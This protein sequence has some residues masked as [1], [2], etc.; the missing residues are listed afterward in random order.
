LRPI[1]ALLLLLVSAPLYGQ[2]YTLH[3]GDLTMTIE[4]A[5]ARYGFKQNGH[6][7]VE[8]S[9]S[10]GM[11]IGGEPVMHASKI[12]CSTDKCS[13]HLATASGDRGT[14]T[15]ELTAHTAQLR[16]VPLSPEMEVGFVTAGAQPAYGLAD[17]AVLNKN[18]STDVTGFSNDHFLSGEGLVRLVS[19]F[20]IYPAQRFAVLLIDPNAKIVHTS[21]AEI[22][23]GVH[24]A[25]AEGTT[26]QYF[27]G[28]MH[29]IYAGY[30]LARIH[31]G[32]KVMPPKYEMFGVGWEA[33]GAL[34]WQ[35][36]QKTI[37][38]S[39]DRYLSLGYPLKWIVI[40]SGFW[41]SPREFNATTSFGLFD[42]IKYP[43]PHG[44]TA[45]FHDEHLK[46]LLGLRIS[47][48][49]DGPFS[50]EGVAHHYFLSENGQAIVFH[51]SWPKSPYYLLDA[52]NPA[53]LDWYMGLT[54]R[55]KDFGVDGYK[56]DFYGYHNL[57]DDKI[58]PVNDRLMAEGADI[59]ERNGYLSV[60]GD[61]QRVNDF[62]YD[63]GQDRG[64]V[65]ALA[66]AYSGFPFVYPDI[67]GGTFGEQHF[68]TQRTPAM[69]TY[70]ERNAQW[71][72]LHSSMSMGEPPWSFQNA[73]VG[74]IML[75]AAQLHDR[76]QPYL[77]SFA[78]RATEDGF[79]WTMSPL[80]IAYPR[81]RETYA[82]ENA[83]VRGYEWL[84]GDALLATP[85]YGNDYATAETRDVYL[86][87][88]QWMDYD[89]GK[90]Y[91]GNT[92][93]TGFA[94]PA[95]KAPLFV[96]GSGVVLEKKGKT[97]VARV[98]PHAA[99]GKSVFTLPGATQKTTV[100]VSHTN[101]AAAEVRDGGN[102][103]PNRLERYAWEFAVD[104]GHT[105]QVALPVR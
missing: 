81:Q 20:I 74:Q 101:V 65:N 50:A 60:D 87:P 104:P 44:L 38:A 24:H 14:M 98:Y 56:E 95:A 34:G 42:K 66:L 79:P 31:A 22:V 7:V 2:T 69:E 63:Q 53:A 75:A 11:V 21:A 102:Q 80:P 51:G 86:P 6:P 90:L 35:T 89:T 105:Y 17:D 91:Q 71:A 82:R 16:F 36:D 94:L 72:A 92:T 85:L 68:S 30:R 40:G 3:A 96:G 49:T 67:V 8:P 19:N 5:G 23:Q 37:T 103:V 13:F 9:S 10:S 61:L 43:D 28:D 45:H 33:F 1:L 70:I 93:L 64:P 88:G 62:N 84:I 54:N 77:Y 47:F 58:D 59:I 97:I 78:L 55:W 83:K 18:Y 39:V 27:F 48:I 57:R 52:H 29:E 4:G 32:Y 73:Q 26:L 46:V 12:S 25:P 76:L 100:T 41:P 15:V 99:E